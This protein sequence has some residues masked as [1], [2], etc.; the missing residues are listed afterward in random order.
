MRRKELR[1]FQI[2]NKKHTLTKTIHTLWCRSMQPQIMDV[3]DDGK[4]MSSNNVQ[5][6]RKRR[7]P[8]SSSSYS[9][10]QKSS[11][12]ILALIENPNFEELAR[13]SPTFQKAWQ[14]TRLKQKESKTRKSFSSCVSQEFTVSLTRAL[15]QIYFDLKLPHIESNHLCPPVPNRFFYL[16]WIQSHLLSSSTTQ[17]QERSNFGL[18]IGTGA[19]CIYPLLAAKFFHLN[20]IAS[21]IDSDALALANSNITSNQM[22][23]KILLL[24]VDQSHSQQQSNDILGGSIEIGGP[25]ERSFRALKATNLGLNRPFDFIMC[26][27]PFYDPNEEEQLIGTP[28][29]GDGRDRTAMTVSEGHYPGGEI[30]FVTDMIADSLQVGHSSLWFS[31]ML[32]KKTSLVMVEKLLYH[33]LGPGHVETTEYGPG[34]YTRWFIAWTLRQPDIFC[35]TARVKHQQPE[36]TFQV[37]LEGLTSSQQ[38]QQAVKE[39]VSRIC[40]FCQSSPGGW[41]L[42]CD[43]VDNDNMTSARLLIKE[44]SFAPIVK[45]V[46]ESEE[47]V[48]LPSTIINALQGQ[49]RNE[50]LPKEGHF[51]IQATVELIATTNYSCSNQNSQSIAVG[52]HLACYRHSTRGFKA[53]EK[54]TSGM[55]GE[56]TRTNRKWRR[57]R[58]RQS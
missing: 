29:A 21:D 48:S 11:S 50:F 32:G 55:K 23:N 41:K 44:S 49:G 18:D 1:K 45:F 51:A 13:R 20:M 7:H 12:E 39:V 3:D 26:N 22:E 31:S 47:N 2:Q 27:P 42:A 24:K 58:Q 56:V 19:T 38:Q 14:E 4:E 35:S 54:I 5:T 34:Q 43:Q 53:I 16:H 8:D 9:M 15:L 28:R 36:T 40:D 52:V 10:V 30:G 25:I 46:D 37:V 17:Q 57:I 33:I 6:S